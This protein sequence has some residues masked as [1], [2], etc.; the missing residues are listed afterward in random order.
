MGNVSNSST[1]VRN[2]CA[3]SDVEM[4]PIMVEVQTHFSNAFCLQCFDWSAQHH[5]LL[6]LR[7]TLD[8]T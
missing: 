8:Q 1:F 5:A 2:Y 6:A 3:P 7:N 4:I